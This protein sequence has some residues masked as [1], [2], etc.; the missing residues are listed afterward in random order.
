MTQKFVLAAEVKVTHV[1]GE[2]LH[3][4]VG[5]TMGDTGGAIRKGCPAHSAE[6][7]LCEVG[8]RVS[9]DGSRVCWERRCTGL[10]RHHVSRHLER[11]KKKKEPFSY[12]VTLMYFD[13]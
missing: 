6:T 4:D 3:P 9:A 13:Y 1:T 5:E 10:T 2:E 12:C 11:P 7:E 8:L